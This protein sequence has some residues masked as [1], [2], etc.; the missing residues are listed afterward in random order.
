[1]TLPDVNVLVGAFRADAAHHL[2][3]RAWLDRTTDGDERFGVSPLALAAVVRIATSPRIFNPPSTVGDAVGFCDQI[4]G[5]PHVET[6][7]PGPR[8]WAIFCRLCV[9]ARIRG[10]MVSDARYAA[11]AIE[12]GCEWISYD[13]DFA[14]F[15]G[16]RWRRPDA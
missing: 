8:H 16:L 6:I 11:L 12:S 7:E 13:R 15:P 9:D 4:L 14:R 5:Q 1:M 2:I 3:C 10:P